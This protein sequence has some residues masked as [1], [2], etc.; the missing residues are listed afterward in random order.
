MSI[1]RDELKILSFAFKAYI[2]NKMEMLS[3]IL[4]TLRRNSM[5]A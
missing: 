3:Y 2:I 4:T 1:G 5:G